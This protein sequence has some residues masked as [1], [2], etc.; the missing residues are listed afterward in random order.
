MEK[1]VANRLQ[2]YLEKNNLITKNQSG[3][4]KHKS[5][6][7]Q[8]LKLQDSIFKKL[9]NKEDVLAI[10]IDFERAYDMLHVPTLLKKLLNMGING[11]IYNWLQN[12]LSNRT[13]Q[14]KVGASL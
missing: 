2:W 14:V 9:K 6:I 11:N 4:R 1:M 12:F 8:I 7:D 5:T 10:F 3:F 13:F